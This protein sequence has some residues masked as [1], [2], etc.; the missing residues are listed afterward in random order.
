[1]LNTIYFVQMF[2]TLYKPYFM[3][4][5]YYSSYIFKFVNIKKSLKRC[6]KKIQN[7]IPVFFKMSK[8]KK[9]VAI[10]KFFVQLL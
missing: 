9:K 1:M 3:F 7:I 5:F 2:T 10:Q 4:F 6:L 8:K